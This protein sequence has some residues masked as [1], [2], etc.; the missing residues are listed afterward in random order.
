MAGLGGEG[1]PWILEEGFFP[2]HLGG[3][4]RIPVDQPLEFE[5]ALQGCYLKTHPGCRHVHPAIDAFD[6]ILK[7]K[8]VDLSQVEKIQVRTYRVAVETEI[9]EIRSRGD[10]YFNIPYALAARAVLGK[11]DWDA[12]GEEHF[13]NESLLGVMKKVNVLA[14]PD[15]ESRY[16]RQRGAGVEVVSKDGKVFSA[17]VDYALGE[18]ENPLP[19]EM[20]REKFRRAAGKFLDAAMIERMESLLG[21]AGSKESPKGFFDALSEGVRR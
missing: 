10:A 3:P 19:P 20:T 18:P 2:A 6:R 8:A 1:Y 15:W 9:H 21:P 11:T 14:D 5:Y 13:R 17:E 7:E 16:P 4:P 12:F